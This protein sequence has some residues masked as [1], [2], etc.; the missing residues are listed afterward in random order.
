[1]I[2][3]EIER[4]LVVAGGTCTRSVQDQVNKH[5]SFDGGCISEENSFLAESYWRLRADR[6]KTKFSLGLFPSQGCIIANDCTH[7]HIGWLYLDS[8]CYKGKKKQK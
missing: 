3:G 6:G 7:I 4:N 2:V 8:V 5:P 1:M